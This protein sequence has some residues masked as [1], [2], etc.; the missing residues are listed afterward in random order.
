MLQSYD[1]YFHFFEKNGTCPQK[2]IGRI[3]KK[4]VNPFLELGCGLG[5]ARR[6]ETN[7]MRSQNYCVATE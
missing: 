1:F 2:E 4:S 5:V 7:P 6:R 3:V